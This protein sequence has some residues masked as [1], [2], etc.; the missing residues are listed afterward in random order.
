MEGARYSLSSLHSDLASYK[1]DSEGVWTQDESAGYRLRYEETSYALYTK[2]SADM[3][4]WNITAGLRGEYSDIDMAE[5]V[6][7]Y[8]KLYLFPSFYSSYKATDRAAVSCTYARRIERVSYNLLM[9]T[10]YYSSSF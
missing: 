9:P 6:E 3:G 8:S 5:G 7:P 10:Q 2:C 1:A 4:R